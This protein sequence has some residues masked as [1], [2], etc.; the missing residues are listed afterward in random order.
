[1]QVLE[2]ERLSQR[3]SLAVC[4]R[5]RCLDLCCYLLLYLCR[6]F[7]SDT[8]SPE[9]LMHVYFNT[10]ES[11]RRGLGHLGSSTKPGLWFRWTAILPGLSVRGSSGLEASRRHP[12]SCHMTDLVAS[13]TC[14]GL[15]HKIM[16]CPQIS[17]QIL[18]IV[19]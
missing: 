5:K 10:F 11:A 13:R 12:T 3:D 9:G 1:M 18:Q 8:T 17:N 15:L 16:C 7:L 6:A 4:R 2:A 19:G 14:Q